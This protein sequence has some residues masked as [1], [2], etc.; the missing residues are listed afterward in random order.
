MNQTSSGTKAVIVTC[1][2]LTVLLLAALVC[3]LVLY[4]KGY[5]SVGR[6][7]YRGD[8][9][10][11]CDL[12]PVSA[13]ELAETE[14][15]IAW[16]K[17]TVRILV[18]GES[19]TVRFSEEG[20]DGKHQ[21]CRRLQD[22]R[23]SV[24]YTK[25]RV[26]LLASWLLPEKTLT[27]T[28]PAGFDFAGITVNGGSVLQSLTGISTK[29]LSLANSAGEVRA[30]N[31][32]AD[33]IYADSSSGGLYLTD[34]GARQLTV[35]NSSGETELRGAAVSSL[36]VESSSGRVQLSGV[37][38][39][40]DVTAVIRSGRI[41][42]NTV[43]ADGTL[44][45]QVNS[46]SVTATG[47]KADRL[48]CENTS[49]KMQ[50]FASEC[51]TLSLVSGSGGVSYEGKARTATTKVNSGATDLR[52]TGR[53]EN[54]D[55]TTA[56]GGVT[57]ALGD[58]DMPVEAYFDMKSGRAASDLDGVRRD[59]SRNLFYRDGEGTVC[60]ISVRSTSGDFRLTS[61]GN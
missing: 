29:E 50:F 61:S 40:G 34:C 45:V 1:A 7:K 4:S 17:G 2:V 38:A 57:I 22:G 25:E 49:G 37:T 11:Q 33:T 10:F 28:I 48:L 19:D 52:L 20:S 6:S 56:S 35:K 23:L 46:G 5:I 30:E 27:V 15:D 26:P 58:K 24:R 3:G 42:M 13:S 31:C 54:I 44:S 55:C 21:F 32:T 18:D 39:T 9:S 16:L 8:D 36:S 14:L 12:S 51:D 53:T 41:E 59:D 60:R 43:C 47:V